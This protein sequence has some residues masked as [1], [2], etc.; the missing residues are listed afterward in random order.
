MI[1]E[2][3]NKNINKNYLPTEFNVHCISNPKSADTFKTYFLKIGS[4]L[5]SKLNLSENSLIQND[6]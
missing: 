5:S 3:L 4:N 2:T 1:N 6:C